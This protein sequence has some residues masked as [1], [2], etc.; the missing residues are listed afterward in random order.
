[1]EIQIKISIHKL[2]MI[3]SVITSYQASIKNYYKGEKRKLLQNKPILSYHQANEDIG[4]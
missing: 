3:Q 4:Y 1:M 2:L